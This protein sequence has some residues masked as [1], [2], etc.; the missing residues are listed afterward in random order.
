MT[1]VLGIRDGYNGIFDSA[2]EP[3]DSRDGIKHLAARRHDSRDRPLPPFLGQSGAHRSGRRSSH[4]R[5]S[6]HSSSSAATAHI[7]AR[8]PCTRIPRSASIGIP[9]SIDNDVGGTSLSIGFD[10]AVNTALDAID[11][12]RD[13]AFSLARMFFVEVMG[14]HS[15]Q[16]ASAVGI[17]SGA[18][19]IVV[20]EIPTDAQRLADI[21]DAGFEVG[22]EAAIIVVAEGDESGGAAALAEQVRARMR[23][24][25]NA[26]VVVL[27]YTQRG[28]SPSAADRL[29]AAR[30]GVAA[31]EAASCGPH[32]LVWSAILGGRER[33][34]PIAHALKMEP[35]FD[36]SIPA[37]ARMLAGIG[38]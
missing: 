33:V 21:I 37:M 32:R 34:T 14:R 31:V 26:R 16:I 28:G 25:L 7:E 27:G 13:T 2:L 4:L 9:G 23:N 8:R 3:L 20:P 17:A 19:A 36:T 11:R 38:E 5:E 22:K 29:L 12:I 24:T 35:Q 18:E 6:I 30:L 1:Q 10:T 15:G